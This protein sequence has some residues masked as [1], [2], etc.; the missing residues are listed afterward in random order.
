MPK[1][2]SALA[3]GSE[4]QLFVDDGIVSAKSGVVRTLHQARRLEQPV[5]RADRP[6]EGRRV[7][8][9]GSVYYDCDAGIFRMW[10]N[11]RLGRGHQHR[12]PGLRSRTGDIILYATSE[13]GVHWEKPDLGCHEFDGSVANN[14]L[15]FDKHSPTVIVG[16]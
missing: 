15:L 11:T 5:L 14:I 1:S 10:Y 4:T 9:Y 16:R 3:I 2:D 6:W 12:A 8:I 7:Y 13:D